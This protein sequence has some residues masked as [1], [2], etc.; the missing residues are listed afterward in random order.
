MKNN[1]YATLFVVTIV[2]FAGCNRK[3]HSSPIEPEKSATEV[4]ATAEYQPIQNAIYHW[5]TTFSLNADEKAFLRR[6]N[7]R[8]IYLR[9]FDVAVEQNPENGI[10]EIVPIATTQLYDMIPDSV[11]VIPTTYIT[12]EALQEM[13]G[14]EKEYA[15][16]IIERLRAMA[17][18]NNCGQTSQ[19]QFDCDWT[20]STEET[21]FALCSEAKRILD[22]DSITLSSTIRLHQ[23]AMDPPPVDCGVLMLYNTG[24]L[25]NKKTR[26]SILD[27]K[28][29]EPYLKRPM[30]YPLPLDYAYPTFGWGVK[31]YMNNFIS[32]VSNPETEERQKNISIRVERPT[33]AEVVAVK[34]LVEKSLGRPASSNILYHLDYS[35]LKNYT[36]DEIAKIYASN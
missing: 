6:H 34:Q 21:Y 36:D 11:E 33:A 7:I 28:D 5:R 4:A 10:L 14:R 24:S 12:F 35:Q 31:F 13:R 17:S 26:N 3:H 15:T 19:M 23:L 8:R 27:I 2:L 22:L 29:V 9:M 20:K 1:L 30:L 18:F 32:I 16:L 25:K